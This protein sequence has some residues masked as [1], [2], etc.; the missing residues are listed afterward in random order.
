M[1]RSKIF[2]W[3][4]KCTEKRTPGERARFENSRKVFDIGC[5]FCLLV[6][7]IS[8]ILAE[9]I[10]MNARACMSPIYEKKKTSEPPIKGARSEKSVFSSAN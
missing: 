2:T 7:M 1:L 6:L 8:S 10:R 3:N 9:V 5:E 4:N